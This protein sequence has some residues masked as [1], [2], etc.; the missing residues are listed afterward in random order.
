M[1]STDVPAPNKVAL[2]EP[3]HRQDLAD[4]AYGWDEL[5][6]WSDSMRQRV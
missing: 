6:L 1:A 2:G 4:G 5:E 3:P